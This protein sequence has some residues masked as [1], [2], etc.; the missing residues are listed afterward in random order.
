MVKYPKNIVFSCGAP[1]QMHDAAKAQHLAVAEMLR[2]KYP[3][4]KITAAFHHPAT[5][6]GMAVNARIRNWIALPAAMRE[7]GLEVADVSGALDGML[8]LYGG[9]DLH[10][11]YR[12]HAHVLMTGWGK[13]SVLV[14]EDGRGSAMADAIAGR[15][16]RA[17]RFETRRRLPLPGRWCPPALAEK[18][19]VYDPALADAIAAHLSE[20]E[21][22]VLN[23]VKLDPGAMRRWFA[24]FGCG[25]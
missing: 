21:G 15:V 7:A 11:G 19:R 5:G 24:Q 16:F 9:A 23:R 1:G 4:A 8:A 3:A 22:R 10:V 14:A 6:E 20:R 25:E 13:A 2:K 17:W 12:V 18:R